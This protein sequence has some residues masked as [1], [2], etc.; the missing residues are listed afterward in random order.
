MIDQSYQEGN[1]SKRRASGQEAPLRALSERVARALRR[2]GHYLFPPVVVL[3]TLLLWMLIVRLGDYPAFILPGPADVYDKL[4]SVIRDGL[5]W[6]HTRITLIEISGGLALGL[7]A[8]TLLGYGMAKS[9]VL[10]R[11]LAPYIV[12]SQ[13][14]PIV[15]LA[16]LLVIWFGTG[17]LSKIL[18]CALTIFFPM[19]VN[20]IVGVRS[21]DPDLAAL[22]RSLKATRWQTFAMLEVPSALPILLGGLKVSVTLSVIGAVVGEFVAADRGLGFLINVARGNFDTPLMFV[23]LLTLVVMALLLYLAVVLAESTL[24]HRRRSR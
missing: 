15:A 3:L 10:E 9:R 11:L 8:A 6:R 2:K 19:L 24:L 21:V 17:R 12:A 22:M 16:P 5:L 1:L 13:S 18:V 23:A 20:T 14:V 7:S 4:T